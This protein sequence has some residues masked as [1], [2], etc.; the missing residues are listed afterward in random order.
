MKCR[1]VNED[2]ADY[3]ES[4]KA[5]ANVIYTEYNKVMSAEVEPVNPTRVH[6]SRRL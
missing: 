6:G 2:E 4:S 1:S 5:V 3:G